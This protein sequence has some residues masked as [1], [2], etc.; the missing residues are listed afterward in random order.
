MI[1]FVFNA[2]KVKHNYKQTNKT[3]LFTNIVTINIKLNVINKNT[4]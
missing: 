1:F 2:I 3:N 4:N